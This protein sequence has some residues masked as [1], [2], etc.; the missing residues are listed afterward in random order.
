MN[1][2]TRRVLDQEIANSPRVS[3]SIAHVYLAGLHVENFA[4]SL[5]GRYVMRKTRLA[6]CVLA[7]A[8]L[9]GSTFAA[10]AKSQKHHKQSSMSTTTSANMK[11]TTP[12]AGSG[13]STPS[14]QGNVGPGANNNNNNGPAPGGK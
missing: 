3:P 10:D 13:S 11:S 8:G 1:I 4:S 9:L 14:S 2:Q 7:V 12:G 6:I 5:I